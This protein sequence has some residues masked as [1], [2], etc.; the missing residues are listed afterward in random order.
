MKR[1]MSVTVRLAGFWLAALGLCAP[2]T[3]QDAVDGAAARKEGKVVWYT[4]TPIEQ[5]QKIAGMFEK[6]TGIKVEL[7]RS[8]GTQVLRRFQQELGAK[9]IVADVMTTSDP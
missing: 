8:G 7:F 1:P 5:A 3:A 4:S 9:R 2:A 6:D